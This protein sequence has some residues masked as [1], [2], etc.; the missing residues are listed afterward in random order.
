VSSPVVTIGP[1]VVS[2]G[3]VYQLRRDAHAVTTLSHAAFQHV[4]NAEL[5]RG[6]F[7]V[8]C[9]ALIRKRRVARDYEKP[10]QLRQPGDDVLGN[11]V[12][13]I[14]LFRI[15]AHVREWKNRNRWPIGC[16]PFRCACR[17][18][19]RHGQLDSV[20]TN[21]PRDVLDGLLAQIVKAKAELVLHLVVN[22]TRHHDA[23]G[24]GQ[25]L[26]PRR[27]IHAVAAA[28]LR[29]I[30]SSA[31]RLPRMSQNVA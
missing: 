7:H 26:K 11:S 20:N 2:G 27:Y 22:D 1:D 30:R 10:A 6:A 12:R 21:R 31:I 17:C 14:F 18:L 23:A 5:A 24:L 15:T 29:S 3:G 25:G 16:G 4:A 9:F 13:E 19:H 28:S 8:D